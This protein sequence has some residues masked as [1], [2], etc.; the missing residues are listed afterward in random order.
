MTTVQL[1][2]WA[3][4]LFRIGR[5]P[6]L[7]TVIL[8]LCIFGDRAAAQ[9]V[10]TVVMSG[11]DNPRSLAFGPEGALYVAEAGRG[12]AGPCGLNTAL[13][14]RCYGPTGAITRLWHGVQEQFVTGLPSHVSPT[15]QANGP[16]GISFQGRGGGYV[17]IGLGDDPA[18]LRLL[19]G[20]AGFLFGTLMHVSA[21]GQWRVTADLAA[22]ERAWNPGGGPIDSNP[23][24]VLAIP[25]A[26]LVADAGANALFEVK[27]NGDISTVAVF[28]SRPL[29][30]TDAVPTA[31]VVG[32]DGAYYVS[33][34]SGMPFTAGAARVYRVVPG[35]PPAV[36]LDGFK[37]ITDLSFGPDGSLYV[38]EHASSP[39]FFGGFGRVLRIETDGTRSV[40]VDGLIR[41][42]SVLVD[43]DGTVYVT[44]H[45]VEIGA[46][47][48]LR[49]APE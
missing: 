6:V 23:F 49:I 30:S 19:L 4:R 13:E 18:V 38:L 10:V 26:R 12:G 25:G 7:T 40:V 3:E 48:V 44:N 22:Y 1:P 43:S 8:V 39:T 35:H 21:S 37:T 42:T 46:G 16:T 17:T 5:T 32:P 29:R 34:L 33:E 11:L 36:F 47:E 24:G 45:G 2:K 9:P 14:I 41:P 15:G 27:A 31:V 20:P 28:P